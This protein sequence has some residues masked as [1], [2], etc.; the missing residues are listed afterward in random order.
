MNIKILNDYDSFELANGSKRGDFDIVLYGAGT[1][2]SSYA[3]MALAALRHLGVEP[4]CFIDDDPKRIGESFLGIPIFKPEYLNL[5]DKKCIVLVSSNYFPSITNTLQ[6]L[7]YQ[8]LLY[9]LTPLLRSSAP[10]AFES[11]MSFDEVLRRLHTHHSKLERFSSAENLNKPVVLNAIDIQVTERCSMKCI[12]CSNLMQYYEQPKDA[13]T[14]DFLSN[15]ATLIRS[16]Q[17]IDDARVLGGEPFMY[18]DLPQI[19]NLLS[20]SEKIVRVTVYSNGTFVPREDI[21]NALIHPKIEVEITDYDEL[22]KKHD[23]VVNTFKNLHIRYITH[24]PQNWTD[25]ARIVKN[26]KTVNELNT[27]FERCC[28]NDALTL[29]HDKLYHCPFSANAYNLKAIPDDSTDYIEFP[30]IE[31]NENI[32]EKINQF[33]FKKNH[34]SAC[35]YCLGRDFTQEAVVAAIQTKKAIPIPVVWVKN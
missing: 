30:S 33:Y 16:V 35:Q 23:Q 29:L 27:M 2:V 11:L 5:L 24:K 34:L 17:R 18:K 10:E 19:L 9:S 7:N 25:S 6:R 32:Q 26:N 8:G 31:K 3:R 28:V 22:S 21:L 1:A 12:D 15:I 20:H 4:L 14:E 13:N